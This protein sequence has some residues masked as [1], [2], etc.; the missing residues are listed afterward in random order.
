MLANLRNEAQLSAAEVFFFFS[1]I[2]IKFE[3]HQDGMRDEN[4]S[5]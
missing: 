3:N 4:T 2:P 5:Q 1:S